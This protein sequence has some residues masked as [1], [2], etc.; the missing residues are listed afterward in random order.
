MKTKHDKQHMAVTRH[1]GVRRYGFETQHNEGQ[2]IRTWPEKGRH[3]PLTIDENEVKEGKSFKRD[4]WHC[5]LLLD[6]K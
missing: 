3:A 6:V 1:V 4:S 2:C 5:H